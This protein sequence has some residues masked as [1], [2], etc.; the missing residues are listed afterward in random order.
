MALETY[1]AL[2]CEVYARVDMIIDKE[3]SSI[4]IRSKY[5][6]R[7]DT[8]SL[9]PKSAAAMEISYADLLDKIIETSL[10]V[11]RGI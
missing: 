9:F 1:K 7:N 4:Y 3:W 2:K 11:K 10:K 5:I 8:A 6:T